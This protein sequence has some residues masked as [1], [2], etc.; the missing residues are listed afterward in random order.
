LKRAGLI[1]GRIFGTKSKYWID[2]EKFGRFK[3][4]FS[5]FVQ[6]VELEKEASQGS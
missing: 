4:L 5:E 1:N 6:S 2:E 3:T